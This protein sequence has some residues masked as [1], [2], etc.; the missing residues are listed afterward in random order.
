MVMLCG[1]DVVT[2]L[3]WVRSRRF[4]THAGMRG[5]SPVFARDHDH[6]SRGG[7]W[8]FSVR[9]RQLNALLGSR[10]ASLYPPSRHRTTLHDLPSCEHL[11]MHI[12]DATPHGSTAKV[13]FTYECSECG[14]EMRQ[15]MTLH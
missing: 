13:D 3:R 6:G 12:K 11:A 14:A 1:G 8:W 7:V 2:K 15:R 4:V 10:H 9:G 5:R